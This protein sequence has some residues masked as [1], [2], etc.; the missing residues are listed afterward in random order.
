MISKE[1][2]FDYIRRYKLLWRYLKSCKRDDKEVIKEICNY[3]EYIPER[4]SD[5]L[6][7]AEFIS[8]NM[9]L[10]DLNKVKKFGKDLALFSK[11][12]YF[13]MT[14]RYIF[15]VKDMIGNII[16]LIGWYPDEKKYV[17]TPS[18]LFSKECLFY[19][20]EQL[21]TTGYGKDYY[22]VEGI[23]D[24]LSVRSLGIPCVAMMGISS[25]RYKNVL[26]SLFKNIVAVPDNDDQ[27]RDVLR[28]DEWEIPMRGKYF[29]WSNSKY[30]IKDIDKLINMYN[31]EDVKDLL[32]EVFKE[33][34]RV[35]TVK[36]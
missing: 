33:N 4:M 1:E 28:N 13:L 25:S 17:T 15:P 2:Y 18:A 5:I 12:G 11:E 3:R 26:Y 20:M 7:D 16:A 23:F 6:H 22:I 21:E 24:S 8:L 36:L 34:Q 14:G 19:G 32:L 30:Y 29:K 10:L 9:E 35:V 27:G 31:K